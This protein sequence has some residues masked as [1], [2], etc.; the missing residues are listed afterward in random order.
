MERYLF[1]QSLEN[2]LKSYLAGLQD[3]QVAVVGSAGDN[4]EQLVTRASLEQKMGAEVD[5]CDEFNRTT[6][7]FTDTCA[8][9]RNTHAASGRSISGEDTAPKG[10]T[11]E[12]DG[13]R[14]DQGKQASPCSAIRQVWF[15]TSEANPPQT[16]PAFHT[17]IGGRRVTMPV[18]ADRRTRTG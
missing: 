9:V 17:A 11:R 6:R 13:R 8:S 5:K 7:G 3:A 2:R 16:S 1:V 10:C 12:Q 15:P 4:P 14:E 18:C